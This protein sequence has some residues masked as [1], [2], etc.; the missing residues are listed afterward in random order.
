MYSARSMCKCMCELASVCVCVCV[1][2]LLVGL[3]VCCWYL[4]RLASIYVLFAIIVDSY[5]SLSLSSSLC[6]LLLFLLYFYSTSFFKGPF[7]V[8]ITFTVVV[9]V[10]VLISSFNGL[11]LT[12][13]LPVGDTLT[14]THMPGMPTHTHTHTK[15]IQSNIHMNVWA[16][17]LFECV[18]PNEFNALLSAL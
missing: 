1:L 10:V 5:S 8:W 9:V 13:P 4:A 16:W 17:H 7:W 11:G 2:L 14:H 6:P 3:T 12:C 18:A 15:Y